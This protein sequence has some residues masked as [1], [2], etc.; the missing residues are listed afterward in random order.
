MSANIITF[1]LA[2]NT[3]KALIHTWWNKPHVREFWD[4]SASMWQNAE[5]YLDNGVKDIFDY[6]IGFY[7]DVPFAL[8]MSS[9]MDKDAP[10]IYQPHCAENGITRS[11]DFMIG[12]EAY[13]GKGLAHLT[14]R[15]FMASCP[16]AVTHFLIDPASSN[17]RAVHVYAKAGFVEV[18]RFTPEGGSFAGKEHI[19]MRCERG[20]N[21]FKNA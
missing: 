15:A 3:D 2:T 1:R 8:V 20:G 17:P 14:L 13:I 12:D 16:P 4:N 9:V 21:E 19:M 10:A 7:D 11:I 5:N 18:G 6:W